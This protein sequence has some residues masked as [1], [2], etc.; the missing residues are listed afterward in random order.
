MNYPD[1]PNLRI[2]LLNYAIE[3]AEKEAVR[4]VTDIP[5]TRCDMQNNHPAYT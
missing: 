3:A 2:P 5:I 1:Y 4:R